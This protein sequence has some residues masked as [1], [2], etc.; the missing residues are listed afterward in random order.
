MHKVA[1]PPLPHSF[2]ARVKSEL[3]I[4]SEPTTSSPP[5]LELT[6]NKH[7]Y[8]FLTVDKPILKW[9]SSLPLSSKPLMDIG[10][11]QGFH[12]QYAIS[13]G[14]DIIAVDCEFSHIRKLRERVDQQFCAASPSKQLR[15]G[16]LVRAVV[17]EVPGVEICKAG[18][19]AGV[20][21][22]EVLQFLKPGAALRLFQDVYRWLQPGGLFVAST[23][24]FFHLQPFLQMGYKLNKEKS[25]DHVRRIIDGYTGESLIKESL[26]YMELDRNNA[27][28]RHMCSHYHLWSTKELT[29]L[30]KKAGFEVKESVYYSPGK[31]PGLPRGARD[32]SVLLVARK[33]ARK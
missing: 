7:G 18:G 27:L 3:K 19:T 29:A 16:E 4:K 26:G 5:S 32:E 2:R 14:R 31:Y 15:M 33:P 21:A 24:S 12:T 9:V 13:K 6:S 20:L 1:K 11:A 17:T 23:L 22:S 28:R 8:H 25:V 30:A 10:S